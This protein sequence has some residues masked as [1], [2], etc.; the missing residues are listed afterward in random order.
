[1]ATKLDRLARSLPDARAIAAV[2][3]TH[4]RLVERDETQSHRVRASTALTAF[5]NA[6]SVSLFVLIPGDK[7]GWAAFVVAVLG[8]MFTTAS[9]LSLIRANRLRWRNLRDV[10]LSWSGSSRSLSFS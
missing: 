7:I 3:V 5:V 6:L 8:L 9:L 2:S 1:M 10:A 4:E